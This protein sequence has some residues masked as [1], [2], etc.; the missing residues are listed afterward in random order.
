MEFLLEF[1]LSNDDIKEIIDNNYQFILDNLVLNKDKV[2]EIIN[3]LLGIGINIQAIKEIFM[4]QVG[5]FFKTKDEIKLSFDEYELD[6]II[7][8]LNYD[9]NN[10]ELIDFI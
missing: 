1:G 9:V 4:Y 10:I 3:Y 5:L 2:S 6:S 7:K 8:S